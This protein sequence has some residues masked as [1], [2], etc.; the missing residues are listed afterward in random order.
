MVYVPLNVNA[1]ANPGKLML[2]LHEEDGKS[3][4]EHLSFISQTIGGT[5]AWHPATYV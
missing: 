1:N 3:L 2:A 4:Y 5:I